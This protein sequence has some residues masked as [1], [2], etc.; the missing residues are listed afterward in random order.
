MKQLTVDFN[1]IHDGLV[2]ALQS[3]AS[4]PLEVGEVVQM[5][6]DEEHAAQ[7]RVERLEG[8]LA[9]LEIDWSTWATIAHL[10]RYGG[11]WASTATVTGQRV[12]IA[13]RTR[14]DF[15][16]GAGWETTTLNRGG[17][18][19]RTPGSRARLTDAKIP[20]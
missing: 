15:G 9:Y 14:S 1:A 4:A 2:R 10:S 17:R 20:A 12:E 8:N 6:D 18:G 13:Y 3:D 11:L 5:T 7:G 19:G 16:A